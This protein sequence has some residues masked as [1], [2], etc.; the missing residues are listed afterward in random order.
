MK[1]KIKFSNSPNYS[2]WI[3]D[4]LSRVF[5]SFEAQDLKI[6]NE[7]QPFV[8]REPK[9]KRICNEKELQDDLDKFMTELSHIKSQYKVLETQSKI[10]CMKCFH[11]HFLYTTLHIQ[12]LQVQLLTWYVG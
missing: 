2:V 5:D 10:K 6:V 4:G 3:N 11:M 12:L 7:V 9:R 8:I 1:K